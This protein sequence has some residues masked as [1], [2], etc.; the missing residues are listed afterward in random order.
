[1]RL[2]VFFKK[3]NSCNT[4]LYTKTDRVID[5]DFKNSLFDNQVLK[6]IL[7]ESQKGR[8]VYLYSRSNEFLL[9]KLI[10]KHKKIERIF[11]PKEPQELVNNKYYKRITKELKTEKF[12]LLTSGENDLPTSSEANQ[13]DEYLIEKSKK[14]YSYTFLKSDF[15]KYLSQEKIS[16]KAL[17]KE[18]IPYAKEEVRKNTTQH[19]LLESFF[20]LWTGKTNEAKITPTNR[21]NISKPK[22]SELVREF[23]KLP[24]ILILVDII[25]TFSFNTHNDIVIFSNKFQENGNLDFQNI[26]LGISF[27]IFL[28]SVYGG[29]YYAT[30]ELISTLNPAYFKITKNCIVSNITGEKLEK[31]STIFI[32]FHTSLVIMS[33]A[34]VLYFISALFFVTLSIFTLITIAIFF[35]SSSIWRTKAMLLTRINIAIYYYFSR[36]SLTDI[37]TRKST[38]QQTAS[39][40][41]SANSLPTQIE[42]MQSTYFPSI[43]FSPLGFFC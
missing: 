5:A 14:L 8:K 39:G 33:L 4:T 30:L 42:A 15:F 34:L 1:M 19:N 12:I 35:L 16:F 41:A 37:L 6:I 43:D 38:S 36:I 10:K 18:F 24:M 21:T 7:N 23:I 26:C 9:P 2:F 29:S 13:E 17:Y 28:P 11:T 31:S 27:L 3:K 22:Q 25:S 20:L 32:I 40:E